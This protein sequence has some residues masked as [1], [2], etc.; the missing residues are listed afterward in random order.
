VRCDPIIDWT[1]PANFWNA[2]GN[3]SVQSDH[4]SHV[5]FVEKKSKPPSHSYI[6]GKMEVNIPELILRV[7]SPI[8][9]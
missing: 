1:V 5:Y 6:S 4:T 7:F 2:H 3:R 9:S 8:T